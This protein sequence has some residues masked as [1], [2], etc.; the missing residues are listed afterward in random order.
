MNTFRKRMRLLA[1]VMCGLFIGIAGAQDAGTDDSRAPQ[2]HHGGNGDNV[3]TIGHDASLAADR[4]A[5][6]VVAI[7]GSATSAGRVDNS[8]VTVFGDA[9]VT[10]EVEEGVVAVAGDSYINGTVNGDVVT[11]M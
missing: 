5:Q 7:F 1:A 3:V 4:H 6:T 10:G 8:V 2:R 11:V 9:H